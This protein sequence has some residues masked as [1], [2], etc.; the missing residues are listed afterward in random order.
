MLGKKFQD[1]ALKPWVKCTL[2]QQAF[3]LGVEVD[4]RILPQNMKTRIDKYDKPDLKH[5]ITIILTHRLLL[6]L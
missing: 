1:A 4:C 2:E 5:I 3:H 6:F